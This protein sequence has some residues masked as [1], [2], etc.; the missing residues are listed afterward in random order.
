MHKAASI[1]GGT[2]I[3]LK[4]KQNGIVV[5]FREASHKQEFGI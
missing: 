2:K 5:N 1:L 3:H 4:V